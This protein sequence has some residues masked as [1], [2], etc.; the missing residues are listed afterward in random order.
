MNEK[1]RLNIILFKN[2]SNKKVL[3]FLHFNSFLD[4]IC[5]LYFNL[6]SNKSMKHNYKKVLIVVIFSVVVLLWMVVKADV[7][8]NMLSESSSVTDLLNAVKYDANSKASDR[9]QNTKLDAM[10]SS[11]CW[12][13]SRY[14]LTRTLCFIREN[15]HDYLQYVIYF[16]LA[17]ATILL[18]RNGFKLVT[19]S[20]K[21][22]QIWAFKKNLIYIIVWV[23]LL[24]WFYVIIDIFVSVTNTVLE[25]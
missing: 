11:T 5:Y 16:W 2:N 6:S 8:S 3:F 4:I 13:D 1:L 7:S 21:D 14:T 20:D 9:V 10:N 25:R 19:A 17:A 24:I 18:I 15:I 12:I 23:V 22:K